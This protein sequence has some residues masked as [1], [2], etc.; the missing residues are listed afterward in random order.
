MSL[1][2]DSKI[3]DFLENIS[4]LHEYLIRERQVVLFVIYETV[5]TGV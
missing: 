1:Y 2:F 3:I 5:R 4:N